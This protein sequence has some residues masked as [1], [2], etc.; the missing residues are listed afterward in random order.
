LTSSPHGPLSPTLRLDYHLSEE[1]TLDASAWARHVE[2]WTVTATGPGA[3]PVGYAHVIILNLT[4]GTDIAD[5]ADPASGMW[6]EPPTQADAGEE[7]VLGEHVLLLDRVYVEPAHRGAA[8]GP[9][10]AAL[11]IT[12]LR[13]GCHLAV[14]FPSPF[15]GPRPDAEHDN[16]VAALGR[17]WATVGFRPRPDGVWVLPLDDDTLAV[18]TDRLLNGEDRGGGVR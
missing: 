14:C 13:R 16:A 3:Y 1:F 4:G 8:L 11:V 15:E 9:I 7:H 12:R 6:R 5:L 18:A 17:I 10:L 2:R